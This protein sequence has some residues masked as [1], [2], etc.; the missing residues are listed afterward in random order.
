M[1]TCG[2]PFPAGT[3]PPNAQGLCQYGLKVMGL[4]LGRNGPNS[5][6]PYSV[7]S[8]TLGCGVAVT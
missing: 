8:L 7:R 6:A 4:K 1:T 3:R 5:S 2:R